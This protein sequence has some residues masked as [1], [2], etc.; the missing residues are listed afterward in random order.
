M[1]LVF[2]KVVRTLSFWESFQNSK[3]LGKLSESQVFG[4][5]FRIP[6]LWESCQN[7]EFLESF[8]NPKFLGELSKS[9]VN[10]HFSNLIHFSI[11]AVSSVA[12]IRFTFNHDINDLT[13][14]KMCKNHLVLITNLCHS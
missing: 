8:E 6:N 9:R 14:R 12:F 13:R 2:W 10:E 11:A 5:V 4:Q 7:P 3:F 1:S